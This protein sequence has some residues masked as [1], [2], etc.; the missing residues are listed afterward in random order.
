M[1][2]TNITVTGTLKDA[3]LAP[4]SSAWL[5]FTITGPLRSSDGTIVACTP[6]QTATDLGGNFSVALV[7]TNDTGTVPQGQV[8]RLEIEAPSL[9]SN[10]IADVGTYFPVYF[11]PLPASYA[12]TVTL[13]TLLAQ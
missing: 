4:V 7:A 11:F 3:N 5:T 9:I 12:P 8:Y 13:N 10:N 2:F 1:G 6:V